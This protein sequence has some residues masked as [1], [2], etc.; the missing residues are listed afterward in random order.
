L[1]A[2]A[3]TVIG[4]FGPIPSATAEETETLLRWLESPG[5]RMVRGSWQSPLKSAARHLGP[6]EDASAAWQDLH[7]TA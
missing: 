3:E 1:L 6:F 5:L 4:G 2:T 7:S